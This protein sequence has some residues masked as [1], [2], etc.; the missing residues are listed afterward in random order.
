M[1]WE[2]TSNDKI[3]CSCGKGTY[4]ILVEMNDW[5]RTRSK[6]FINCPDC[7]EKEKNFRLILNQN[8][9]RLEKT[10]PKLR[11][12]FKEK[13]MVQWL[14]YFNSAMTKK[15]YWE[16]AKEIGVEDN[17]LPLFYQHNKG[18]SMSEYIKD[19]AKQ[20]KNM[21]IIMEV[22]EI[23]D[24]DLKSKLKEIIELRDLIYKDSLAINRWQI[25]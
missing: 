2:E 22:L 9:E 15:D 12:Y 11:T 23:A 10:A 7:A 19:L 17:S 18:K 25:P 16:I 13:Y 14:S 4:T 20:E 1:S 6:R 24:N 21:L 8:S 5:N 3:P